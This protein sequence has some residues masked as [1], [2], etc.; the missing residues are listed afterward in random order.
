MAKT[1]R[2]Y[3]IERGR[4]TEGEIAL[5]GETVDLLNPRDLER[6]FLAFGT[7]YYREARAVGGDSDAIDLFRG[8][9]MSGGYRPGPPPAVGRSWLYR[10]GDLAFPEA[11][12]FVFLA[13]TPDPSLVERVPPGGGRIARV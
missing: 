9:I 12:P 5:D 3:G 6:L 7:G 1:V 2:L 13:P 11:G 8:L 10:D 4:E